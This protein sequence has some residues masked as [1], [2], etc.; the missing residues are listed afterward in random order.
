M[1]RRS[2]FTDGKRNPSLI[3][4]IG[5]LLKQAIC[6]SS[7]VKTKRSMALRHLVIDK[8]THLLRLPARLRKGQARDE[9]LAARLRGMTVHA[10]G[11]FTV[12]ETQAA[13][14][15]GPTV[16]AVRANLIRCGV[17]A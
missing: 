16:T 15:R 9:L 5:R 2:L 12:E 8:M 4:T 11:D 17:P 6:E 13:K 14:E 1:R 3:T 7:P 10:A